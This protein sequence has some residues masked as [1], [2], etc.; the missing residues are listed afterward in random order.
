M[1][2]RPPRSTL[3]PYTTLFRS[4]VLTV[5][6]GVVMASSALQ[7]PVVRPVDEKVLREYPG[8]YQWRSNAFV[9]LQIWDEGK[10]GQLVAFEEAG[11][12]RTL[13]PTDYDQFF[14]GPGAMVPTS[15]ESRIN[16]QRGNSGQ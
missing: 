1:I 16:F 8:V 12:V 9:Y 6:S 13:Y 10:P 14:A 7:A 5:L 11:D 15:V 4:T 2:R 3:F